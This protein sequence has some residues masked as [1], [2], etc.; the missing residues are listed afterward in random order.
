MLVLQNDT[1]N[2]H[3]STTI[4]API[5]TRPKGAHLPVHCEL[6]CARTGLRENSVVLLEQLRVIDKSRLS[7]R[8]GR[9]DE[10]MLNTINNALSISVGLRE[11]V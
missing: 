8:I 10:T 4:I 9:I 7:T 2:T 5:T 11:V 1:G 6:P 3:S